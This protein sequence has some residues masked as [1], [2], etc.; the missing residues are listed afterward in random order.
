M[1]VA[2]QGEQQVGE[3]AL[4]HGWPLE[5][6]DA[7]HGGAGTGA[8]LPSLFLG[9]GHATEAQINTEVPLHLTREAAVK[10]LQAN[11]RLFIS[12]G[13]IC[14]VGIFLSFIGCLL[15]LGLY[16]ISWLK[17]VCYSKSI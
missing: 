11:V 17:L 13:Q 7:E 4:V 10:S 9:H 5:F 2:L 6:W 3:K 15:F 1:H 12:V 8:E 16:Q 14:F